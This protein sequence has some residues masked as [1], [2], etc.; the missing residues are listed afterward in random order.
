MSIVESRFS[1][2]IIRQFSGI[3]AGF[4]FPLCGM[5]HSPVGIFLQLLVWHLIADVLLQPPVMAAAK[6]KRNMTGIAI[7]TAHG[8][9]HGA[10]TGLILGSFWIALLETGAHALVDWG[11]CRMIYGL[12]ADQCAHLIGL[13]CWVYVMTSV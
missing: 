4:V 7:L 9:I 6:R 2:N 1:P 5:F 11:K 10:G 3:L 13:G 8:L 12:V